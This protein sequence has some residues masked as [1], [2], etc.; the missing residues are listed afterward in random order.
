MALKVT[1]IVVKGTEPEA[2]LLYRLLTM[3]GGQVVPPIEAWP[4]PRVKPMSYLNSEVQK[5]ATSALLVA[6][7]NLCQEHRDAHRGRPLSKKDKQIGKQAKHMPRARMDHCALVEVLYYAMCVIP[8]VERGELKEFPTMIS[9]ME[10]N[11]LLTVK[12]PTA[13]DANGPRSLPN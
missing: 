11:T 5:V 12:C 9:V 3:L 7:M 13:L 10:S 8:G 4:L 2:R 6:V 1:K